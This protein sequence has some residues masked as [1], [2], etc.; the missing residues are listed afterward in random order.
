MATQ[1][2]PNQYASQDRAQ[3]RVQ[4]TFIKQLIENQ[5]MS[6]HIQDRLEKDRLDY[7]DQRLLKKPRIFKHHTETNSNQLRKE[8][9]LKKL[10]VLR[11]WERK[12]FEQYQYVNNM[13]NMTVSSMEYRHYN[14]TALKLL[15][16]THSINKLL[17]QT[18]KSFGKNF[19]G[20][21][22]GRPFAT[23]SGSNTMLDYSPTYPNY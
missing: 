21:T 19:Y 6:E 1:V 16:P 23:L 14:P 2:R 7:L 3:N 9:Q 11:A 17:G 10:D 15:K 18:Q 13:S 8:T 20:S 22:S 4:P 5:F 12:E